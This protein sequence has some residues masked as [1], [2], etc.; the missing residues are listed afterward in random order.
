MTTAEARP[1]YLLDRVVHLDTHASSSSSLTSGLDAR[2]VTMKIG[3]AAAWFNDAIARLDDLAT[4]ASD[5]DSYGAKPVAADMAIAAVRFLAEVAVASPDVHQPSIVPLAD[6]GIQVEW[7]RSGID[8]EVTFSDDEPG[9]YRV[10]H[11]ANETADRPLS[12][13]LSE[14]LR[15]ATRLSAT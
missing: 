13:A 2:V 1:Q 12:D 11:I 14:V 4:L 5:W 7:H 8:L 9:V 6:G 10:D 3:F 15:V